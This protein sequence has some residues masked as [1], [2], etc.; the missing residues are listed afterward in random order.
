MCFIDC[1]SLA[2]ISRRFDLRNCGIM[3]EPVDVKS[4]DA[5]SMIDM[6]VSDSKLDIS[7]DS[8]VDTSFGINGDAFVSANINAIKD[9]DKSCIV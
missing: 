5:F 6:I 8:H 3:N 7:Y 4:L 9:A 1:N 2:M